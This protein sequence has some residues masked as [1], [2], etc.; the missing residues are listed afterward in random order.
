MTGK[1]TAQP[2]GN[3]EPTDITIFPHS[4]TEIF[5]P[6]LRNNPIQLSMA[7]ATTATTATTSTTT[8]TSLNF[9]LPPATLSTN[10]N[11]PTKYNF[12]MK[13][14]G[15]LNNP[16]RNSNKTY[17]D[18]QKKGKRF[19][20]DYNMNEDELFL[21]T[22]VNRQN[23][24]DHQPFNSWQHPRFSEQSSFI[25]SSNFEPEIKKIAN[26]K[27]EIFKN[28]DQLLAYF[29]LK[30]MIVEQQIPDFDETCNFVCQLCHDRLWFKLLNFSFFTLRNK[31]NTEWIENFSLTISEI[32]SEDEEDFCMILKQNIHFRKFKIDCDRRSI[33]FERIHGMLMNLK[34]EP[35]FLFKGW[36][37]I[38]TNFTSF[39]SIQYENIIDLALKLILEPI[40]ASQQLLSKILELQFLRNQDARVFNDKFNHFANSYEISHSIATSI[41]LLQKPNRFLEE[42]S[43]LK[44]FQIVSHIPSQIPIVNLEI[45]KTNSISLNTYISAMIDDWTQL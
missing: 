38:I 45:F 6:H 42:V 36:E 1:G 35:E 20:K 16:E 28:F 30:L 29:K 32:N 9:K 3:P 12:T 37:I 11:D 44:E 43:R 5:N 40:N 17:D 19:T 21:T 39:E 25:D 33:S 26:Q 24:L 18:E 13:D 23:P 14:F 34:L 27:N 2:P 41:N 10:E 22:K 7:E 4:T 8:K 31:L 15:F